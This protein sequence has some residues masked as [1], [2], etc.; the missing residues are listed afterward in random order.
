MGKKDKRNKHGKHTGYLAT[1]DH[2][3]HTPNVVAVSPHTRYARFWLLRI[4]EDAEYIN[5]LYGNFS[6]K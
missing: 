4:S 2:G 1:C 3:T 6:K 5:N